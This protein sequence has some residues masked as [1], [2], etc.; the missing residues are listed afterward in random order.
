MKRV[1]PITIGHCGEVARMSIV[2]IIPKLAM[3]FMTFTIGALLGGHY[4]SFGLLDTV[5]VTIITLTKLTIPFVLGCCVA[6]GLLL[7]SGLVGEQTRT[8]P[9]EA[10]TPAAGRPHTSLP[11]KFDECVRRIPKAVRAMSAMS[12]SE[13]GN[14]FDDVLEAELNRLLNKCLVARA[15]V[16]AY[17]SHDSNCGKHAAQL[18]VDLGVESFSNKAVAPSIAAVLQIILTSVRENAILRFG[19]LTYDRYFSD[20]TASGFAWQPSFPGHE[21]AALQRV[22]TGGGDLVSQPNHDQT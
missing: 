8:T 16:L 22:E 1:Q 13:A 2:P 10:T 14:S 3:T 19:V 7:G 15:A 18:L 17:I 6:F 11:T 12:A 21:F 4:T 5:T 9:N 20:L